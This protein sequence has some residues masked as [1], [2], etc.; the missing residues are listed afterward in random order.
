MLGF[1]QISQSTLIK[2]HMNVSVIH[3]QRNFSDEPHLFFKAL[4]EYEETRQMHQRLLSTSSYCYYWFYPDMA[5]S[6]HS[7]P[8]YLS[9]DSPIP[10]H[11]RPNP[12][13][14]SPTTPPRPVSRERPASCLTEAST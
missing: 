8:G 14:R 9:E 5:V 2:I 1:V 7:Y 6:S 13:I 4:K 3:I 10:P 11:L 12:T